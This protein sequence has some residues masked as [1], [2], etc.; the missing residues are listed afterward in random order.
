MADRDDYQVG[1]RRPP[2]EHRFKPGRSGNP[3]GRPPGIKGIEAR[4]DDE[5]NRMVRVQL[6]GRTRKVPMWQAVMMRMM[7]SALK[8]DWRAMQQVI[9]LRLSR[10]TPE[11]EVEEAI[12]EL[13]D[14]ETATLERMLA[15][16]ATK[17]EPR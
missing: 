2:L 12:D 17:A 7:Q 8:G 1:Y 11:S 9:A 14:E 6:E 15:R 10:G 4:L 3:R 5:L 16:R 13:S